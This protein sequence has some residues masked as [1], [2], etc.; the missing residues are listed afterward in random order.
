[1]PAISTSQTK[2]QIDA[3]RLTLNPRPVK[4]HHI[5]QWFV[6]RLRVYRGRHATTSSGLLRAM[7]QSVGDANHWLDHWGS[8]TSRD[9]RPAF[10]AE[11]YGFGPEV[12]GALDKLAAETGLEW[13]V[14]SNSW[15]YPGHTVRIEIY[16]PR[17]SGASS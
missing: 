10:V 13:S 14:E 1:M 12:A 5:P 16:E 11:P 4:L 17:V 6:R 7:L 15:W 9:G 3:A 8:S 2:Q